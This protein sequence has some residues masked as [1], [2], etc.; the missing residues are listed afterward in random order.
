MR[1]RKNLII[2]G[3]SSLVIFAFLIGYYYFCILGAQIFP[4]APS[5]LAP[6]EYL[7]QAIPIS[8]ALRLSKAEISGLVWFGDYLIFLPQYPHRFSHTTNGSLFAI[9]E[10]AIIEYLNGSAAQELQPITIPLYSDGVE[11]II[12]GY[13]GFEAIAISDN[14]VYLAIEAQVG[15]KMMGYLV[16]GVISADLSS[17]RLD[18]STLIR[19]E[20]QINRHNKSDEA[21]LVVGHDIL[22]FFELNGKRLNPHPTATRYDQ[23]L[24][25]LAHIFI[26]PIEYRITDATSIDDDGQFWVINYFYPLEREQY[27]EVDPI[28]EL[29]GEGA[30]HQNWNT[31]ERLLALQYNHDGIRLAK[32]PPVQLVLPGGLQPRNWE[33]IA[34]LPGYGFLLVTDK[35][36][37]T[38]LGFV[39][40]P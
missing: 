26:P 4:K 25:F 31:V 32:I 21:L 22:T 29:Y 2:V 13:Q 17:V 36:P 30:T 1:W 40:Y 16:K 24:K 20:P 9:H 8:G 18:S 6:R 37:S 34:R 15:K 11:E 38:I 10:Q 19:N 28:S 39:A 14:R 33:G 27:L 3:L 5:A 23:D 7:V 12:P 35:Y